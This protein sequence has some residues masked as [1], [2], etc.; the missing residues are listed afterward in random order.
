M[1]EWRMCGGV[2]KLLV[3]FEISNRGEKRPH[4]KSLKKRR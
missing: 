2:F 1:H 4:E 3:P